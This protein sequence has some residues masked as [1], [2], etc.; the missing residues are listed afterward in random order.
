MFPLLVCRRVHIDRQCVLISFLTFPRWC[1]RRV[2]HWRVNLGMC[3]QVIQVMILLGQIVL[4][5]IQLTIL[6]VARVAIQQ[7]RVCCRRRCDGW[8]WYD[9]NVRLLRINV[10]LVHIHIVWMWDKGRTGNVWMMSECLCEGLIDW[11]HTQTKSSSHWAWN[12]RVVTIFLFGWLLL[13]LH[14]DLIKNKL[15]VFPQ[16]LLS[17]K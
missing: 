11:D 10:W 12:Q 8:V 1:V 17:L 5:P 16:T 6:L 2:R 3:T 7:T 13:T 15:K 14:L 9:D 4:Q